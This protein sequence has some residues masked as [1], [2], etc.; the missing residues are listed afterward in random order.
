MQFGHGFRE[1]RWRLKRSI[2]VSVILAGSVVSCRA[3]FRLEV[4]SG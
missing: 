2:F 3:A 1:L 4:G